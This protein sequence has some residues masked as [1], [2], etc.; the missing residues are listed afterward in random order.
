VTSMIERKNAVLWRILVVNL[1]KYCP[2]G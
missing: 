1:L 2:Q